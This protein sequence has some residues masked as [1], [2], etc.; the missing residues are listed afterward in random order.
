[1][2]VGRILLGMGNGAIS[3][4]PSFTRLNFHPDMIIKLLS[5]L[6]SKNHQWEQ[7]KVDLKIS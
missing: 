3:G 5:L 6:S 7:R 2:I 4:L 1:M